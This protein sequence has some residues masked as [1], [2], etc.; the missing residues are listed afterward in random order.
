MRAGA[1]SREALRAALPRTLADH[2]LIRLI[3]FG[4]YGDV[5]LGRNQLTGTHRAI[6]IVWRDAFSTSKPYEREFEGIKRFEPVSRKHPGFVH[7]LQTGLLEFGFYYIMELAD[8]LESVTDM[9][10]Y[11][12]ATLAS[13]Q[14][15]HSVPEAIRIGISLTKCLGVLHSVGLIHRDIKPSNIIFVDGAPKLADIG[16]IAA[17]SEANSFVGT[18]GF[19]A[20]EGPTSSQSDIYSLGKLL[21]EIATGNDRLEFPNLPADISEKE[22]LL[23]ELNQVI[24]KACHPDVRHRYKSVQALGD[25]LEFLLQGKSL[26]RVRQLENALRWTRA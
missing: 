9:R 24:L 16:L 15:I 21:Y 19:I 25:E 14:Q 12:P 5:W 23:L 7:I 3:A 8:G 22:S 10:D 18:N 20:P 1:K 17:V 26:K 6:K 2:E 4:S 11:K 13:F